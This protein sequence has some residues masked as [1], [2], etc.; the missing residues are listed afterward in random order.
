MKSL[1]LHNKKHDDVER[2][3]EN[4]SFLEDFPHQ[5]ITGH[6]TQMN[7]IVVNTLEKHG[8]IWSYTI[9]GEYGSITVKGKNRV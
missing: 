4:Y 8:F 2:L 7:S 9:L 5:I 6:S 1:D 3:V